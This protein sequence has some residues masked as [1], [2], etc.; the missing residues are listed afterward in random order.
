[1]NTV[2][3]PSASALSP[4]APPDVADPAVANAAAASFAS[5]TDKLDYL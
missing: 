4:N 2:L 1:V 5:L 3:P